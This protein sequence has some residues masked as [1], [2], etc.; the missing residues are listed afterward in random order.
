MTRKEADTLKT[1]IELTFSDAAEGIA[2]CGMTDRFASGKVVSL[3]GNLMPWLAA[4]K[5][6]VLQDI[7]RQVED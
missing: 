7:E 2:K 3:E 4:L 6:V 1:D 5:A